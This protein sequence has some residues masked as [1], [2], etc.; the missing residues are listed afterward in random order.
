MI[1]EVQF[2]SSFMQDNPLLAQGL[3]SMLFCQ[4]PSCQGLTFLISLRG[5]ASISIISVN[6]LTPE[7]DFVNHLPP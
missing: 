3:E 1:I 5:F 2:N 7:K 4:V 6:T